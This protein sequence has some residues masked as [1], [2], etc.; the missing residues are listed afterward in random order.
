M[1]KRLF[2]GN[3]PYSTTAQDLEQLFAQ[4][5]TVASMTLITDKFSGQSKGFAFAEMS[6]D[7]EFENAL[8]LNG[9]E[10]DGRQIVV[11]EARPREERPQ[12]DRFGGGNRDNRDRR[13]GSGG[14]FG[15]AKRN[16]W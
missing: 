5:G 4:A 11:N 9:H 15:G 12:S 1:A 13:G 2:I 8:K 7:E 14:G 3:L 10:L 16:R 6:S